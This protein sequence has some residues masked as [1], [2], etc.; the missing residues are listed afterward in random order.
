MK[1]NILAGLL[2]VGLAFA[3]APAALAYS[4]YASASVV[5]NG[6]T[7]IVS[8]PF[9]YLQQSD[10]NVYINGTLQAQS[11]Y[12][13]ATANTIQLPNPASS[14]N[15]E[16]VLVARTTAIN[17]AD[18]TFQAGGIDPNDLNTQALQSLYGLQELADLAMTGVASIQTLLGFT[19][20]NPANNLSDVA[21]PATARTNL[22]VGSPANGGTGQT[23]P[24]ANCLEVAEGSATFDTA[25]PSGAGQL[26]IS[27]ASGD[28]TFEAITGDVAVAAGGAITLLPSTR[29]V[30]PVRQTVL[31]GPIN[32]TLPALLPPSGGSLT[33]NSNSA[34]SSIPIVISAAF[35][36]GAYGDVN[37]VGEITSGSFS[38]SCTA[39]TTNYLYVAVSPTGALTPGVT[40][41]A[42]IYVAGANTY[43]TTNGQFTFDIERMMMFEGNG[44][45]ANQVAAVFV[46]EAIA[47][48]ASITSTVIYAY[49]GFIEVPGG[50][51]PGPSPGL[52]T[53]THALGTP[54]GIPQMIAT[55][56]STE[57]GF[58]LGDHAQ[59]F[60]GS[61]GTYVLP[62]TF[63]INFHTV[64]FHVG[65]SGLYVI[66]RNTGAGAAMTPS[67]WSYVIRMRRGWGGA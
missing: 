14:Y 30:S 13:W 6:S 28:P 39:S 34:S 48:S 53:L 16:T 52:Y 54:D 7:N 51:L 32:N 19:P 67:S 56:T 21:N 55:N 23:N 29:P 12:T 1:Q 20:M 42:P 50:A 46:G 61:N 40:T 47:G 9:P 18:V 64:S 36:S 3:P 66:N 37:Y 45:T 62:I 43:S 15:G 26:P 38:W 58:N 57:L 31:T 11:S 8:V 2:A 49:R 24:T 10:V 27:Q 65:S 63:D 5:E 44:T 35:G 17:A 4:P 59:V 41:L 60:G 25:C 33:F 22:G